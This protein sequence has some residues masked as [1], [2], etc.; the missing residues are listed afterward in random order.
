MAEARGNRFVSAG[1]GVY[2]T[3]GPAAVYSWDN[4]FE[5]D[6]ARRYRFAGPGGH[7]DGQAAETGEH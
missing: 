6:I 2:T 7:I 1:C 5:E 4:E 3:R